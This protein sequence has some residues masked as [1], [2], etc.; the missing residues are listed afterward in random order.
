MFTHA[1]ITVFIISE[2]I[3][4]LR[5]LT[6]GSQPFKGGG[7]TTISEKIVEIL[8]GGIQWGSKK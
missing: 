3:S 8:L 5:Q 4:L 6:S 1:Q 7:A 2:E